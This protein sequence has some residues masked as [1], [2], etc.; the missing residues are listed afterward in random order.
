MEKRANAASRWWERW[1]EF[2]AAHSVDPWFPQGDDPIPYLQ[3]FA[4]RYRDGRL[5]P[6]GNPVRSG[7]VADA[8]R[9][10]GQAYA[11]LGSPDIR[12]DATGS[13][14]FCLSRQ[15][16]SYTKEDPPSKRVKPVPIQVVMSV[17]T[18][19][20]DPAHVDPGFRAVAD[21]ICLGFYFMLRPGEH[22]YAANNTPFTLLR[23]PM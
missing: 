20:Y 3:V 1:V 11:S 5:A 18:A 14:D 21:M 8:L 4:A 19:A 9:S 12:L 13:L 23:P 6:R 22:T 2:C 10:I 17:L 16:R 15:L 7:S